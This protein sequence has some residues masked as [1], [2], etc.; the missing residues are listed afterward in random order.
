MPEDGIIG[1]ELAA[2]IAELQKDQDKPHRIYGFDPVPEWYERGERATWDWRGIPGESYSENRKR[3]P[4]YG[5]VPYEPYSKPLIRSR[6]LG[7]LG[8]PSEE[9]LLAQDLYYLDRMDE[10]ESMERRKEGLAKRFTRPGEELSVGY[11]YEPEW[12]ERGRERARQ[13]GLR[14][15]FGTER[16][17][18]QTIL[19]LTALMEEE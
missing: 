19:A 14:Q 9:T 11:G 5:D 7:P 17:R 8:G 10:L 3:H 1:P 13:W 15:Q 6:G 2:K 18:A 4:D 16:E 12:E